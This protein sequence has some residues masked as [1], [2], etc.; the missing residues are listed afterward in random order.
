MPP[1]LHHPK[2]APQMI[3]VE[4]LS[5]LLD[6][7]FRF[8]GTNFRF[9]IDPIIGLIPILGDVSSLAISGALLM[10]MAKHGVSRKLLLLM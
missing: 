10:T 5:W 7:Q 3:W 6:S 8:P 4:R 9:G 1:D 2:Q